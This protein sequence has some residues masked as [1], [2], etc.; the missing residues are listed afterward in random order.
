MS[1]VVPNVGDLLM[2]KFVTN[3]FA[4][5]ETAGPSGGD[6]LLR[7]FTN[8]LNPGKSTVIGDITEATESGYAAITLDGGTW[9]IATVSGVNS[10]SYPIQTFTFTETAT[11]YGYYITTQG[12]SLLWA[13]RFS[14]GP[15]VLTIDGGEVTVVPAIN[16]N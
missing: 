8:N 6:R 4:T 2:L 10:A 15:Y 11:I 1:L 9:T 12:D 13:E 16:F 14:D 3:Y 5:D 7:L